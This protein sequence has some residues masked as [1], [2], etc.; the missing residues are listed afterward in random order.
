MIRHDIRQMQ[1]YAAP[2]EGATVKLDAMELPFALPEALK[3][4]ILRR[5]EAE[6]IHRYP[7]AAARKLRERIAALH[8]V[9]PEQVIVGNGSDEIIQMVMIASEPGPVA[10]P[11]PSFVMYEVI[12]RW[13]RRPIT[14]LPLREDFSLDAERFL[15]L[16]AREKVELVFLACPNNP[17]GNLWPRALVERIAKDYLGLVVL[18][19]AYAPYASANHMDL[20]GGNVLV[21]RSFS[22]VGFAGA[23]LGYAVGAAELVSELQKVRLPYNVNRFTQAAALALLEHWDAVM[24][25]VARVKEERARLFAAL[26]ELPGLEP[27]PSETNF[28]LVRAKEAV[29]VHAELARRGIAVKNLDGTHP[30]LRDCLRITVGTREENDRLLAA[31]EEILA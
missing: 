8:N 3:R 2:E 5:M 16:C 14:S 18:D 29:H 27:Y 13:L 23:R 10:F 31:L 15:Q 19:E 26:A 12:A 7:D 21:M 6:P 25:L 9:A 22:K 4:D 30:L 17:T 20:A 28:V 24:E 11:S 1:A